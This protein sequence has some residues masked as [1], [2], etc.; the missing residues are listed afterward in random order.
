MAGLIDIDAEKH[1]TNLLTQACRGL[2]V[3]ASGTVK[4]KTTSGT[5]QTFYGAIRIIPVPDGIIQV[6]DTGTDATLITGIV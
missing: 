6:Y 5:E 1:D 2:W 3:G 4:V